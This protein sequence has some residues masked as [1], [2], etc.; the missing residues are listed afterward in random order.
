MVVAILI[1][2]A[3]MAGWTALDARTRGRS[4]Y[5]WSRIVFFTN[6][7]GLVAW[8]VMRRRAPLTGAAISQLQRIALVVSGVPLFLLTL[9]LSTTMTAF[10]IEPT[11]VTGQAMSPTITEGASVLV[12]KLSYRL[13]HPGRGDVVLFYYPL[14]PD[15]T[16]VKRV[17]AEE[18][19][20]VR[21]QDGRVFVND[22]E[23]QEGYVR[24]DL[25]SHDTWGPQ[26]VPEGYYFVM[27]DH[28][29]NSS[30]S[31]HWGFVPSRYVIGKVMF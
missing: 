6:V 31:R 29:N 4:W 1:S 11:R 14:K 28:R 15:K 3:I 27:G 5:T 9:L 18:G 10:V 12:N 13:R 8:L 24:P 7:I 23:L 25:R 2:S 21:I 19:D 26:V 17:I 30:D 22:V 16:L 20:S